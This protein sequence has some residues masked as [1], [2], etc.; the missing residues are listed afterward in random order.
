VDIGTAQQVLVVFFEALI[1][2][3]TIE[4]DGMN[5]RIMGKQG[6]EVIALFIFYVS[7]KAALSLADGNG[8]PKGN[9]MAAEHSQA[10]RIVSWWCRLFQDAGHHGPEA[11]LGMGIILPGSKR[12]HAGHGTQNEMGAVFVNTGTEANTMK[13]GYR[14]ENTS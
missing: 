5:M 6:R 14:Q 12:G 4:T 9:M 8:I 3:A 11:I 7:I 2:F 1:G 10:L 13:I